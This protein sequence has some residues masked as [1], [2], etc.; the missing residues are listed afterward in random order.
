MKKKQLW[1]YVKLNFLILAFLLVL[2]LMNYL[3]KKGLSKNTLESLH[4][5]NRSARIIPPQPEK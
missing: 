2:F 3:N 4:L 1:L 5:Q